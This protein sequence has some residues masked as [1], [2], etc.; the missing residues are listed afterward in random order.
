MPAPAT[1]G[2]VARWRRPTTDP[3]VE[4]PD[5]AAGAAPA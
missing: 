5:I 1:A 3:P 4:L 2:E